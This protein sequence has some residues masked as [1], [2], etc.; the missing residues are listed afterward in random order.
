MTKHSLAASAT[1][2]TIVLVMAALLLGAY[3]LGRSHAAEDRRAAETAAQNDLSK[4]LASMQDA[5]VEGCRAR[6]T[7][8]C[9]GEECPRTAPLEF[10]DGWSRIM[11]IE[12]MMGV[13]TTA[14]LN[15]RQSCA[16]ALEEIETLAD[17]SKDVADIKT[18]VENQEDSLD[19]IQDALDLPGDDATLGALA[20]ATSE[21]VKTL[22][23]ILSDNPPD[24]SSPLAELWRTLRSVDVSLKQRT[25]LLDGMTGALEDMQKQLARQQLRLEAFEVTSQG[26][27]IHVKARL[28]QGLI[29]SCEQLDVRLVGNWKPGAEPGIGI[30]PLLRVGALEQGDDERT[31]IGR[32]ELDI[33]TGDD[34]M[35]DFSDVLGIVTGGPGFQPELVGLEEVP[36]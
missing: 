28:P 2:V 10:R 19:A 18:F 8:H 1:L 24:E 30:Y 5:L 33:G 12:S 34:S 16:A 13:M 25:A 21:N 4:R 6:L 11:G 22:K 23:A 15:M 31:C 3:L 27:A 9:A 7:Q 35:V 20:V 17:I 29:P 36:R 14:H 26:A 32:T